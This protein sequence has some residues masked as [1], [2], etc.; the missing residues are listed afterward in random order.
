MGEGQAD[1]AGVVFPAKAS[2]Q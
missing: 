2:A 1:G